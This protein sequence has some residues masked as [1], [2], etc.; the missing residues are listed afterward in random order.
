MKS[1]LLSQ[2]CDIQSNTV[3]LLMLTKAWLGLVEYEME[4]FAEELLGEE[5][6][7]EADGESGGEGDEQEA[8][9]VIN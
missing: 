4:E 8:S 6:A 7:Y 2:I 3:R 5:G 9:I 1:S